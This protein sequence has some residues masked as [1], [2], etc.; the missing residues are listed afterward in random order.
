MAAQPPVD[1]TEAQDP[2]EVDAIGLPCPRPV[3]ELANAVREVPVGARVL[4]RA[5]DPAAAVD[6][7]VW[8]RMQGQRLVS[9]TEDGAVLSFLVEKTR[10]LA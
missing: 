7:P 2:R 9:R 5:D 10:Q 4:L 8:C 1:G 6:V 3:I